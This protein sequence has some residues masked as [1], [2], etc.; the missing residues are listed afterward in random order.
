MLKSYEK[1][2]AGIQKALVHHE[3]DPKLE[4]TKLAKIYN[5]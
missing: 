1:Q 2:E 5:I 4:F 3:S